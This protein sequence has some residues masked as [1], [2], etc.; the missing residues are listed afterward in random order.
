[1]PNDSSTGGVLTPS[2]PPPLTDASLEAILQQLV[3]G[4]TGLPGRLVRPRWQSTTPKQPEPST[5]WCAI[6]VTSITPDAN[7][8][9]LHNAAGGGSDTLFRHEQIEVLLSFYG[10]QGQ[11]YAAQVR[12]GFWLPQNNDALKANLMGFVEADVLRSVPELVNQQW[13]RRY[14]FSVWLRRQVVR[15]YPVLNL[16]SAAVITESDTP[17]LNGDVIVQST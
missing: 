9:I 7:P 6:G 5:N 8:A 15:T 2:S 17:L 11:Q 1:M 13:V 12:D 14:D 10:P 4:L 16:L 3:V